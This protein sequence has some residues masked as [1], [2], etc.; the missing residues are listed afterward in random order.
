MLLYQYGQFFHVLGRTLCFG[1][2]VSPLRCSGSY[3]AAGLKGTMHGCLCCRI[4]TQI[5]KVADPDGTI[6]EPSDNLQLP[7]HRFDVTA[8]C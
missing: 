2:S 3:P 7:P 6:R 1:A 8:Q 4:A 5:G